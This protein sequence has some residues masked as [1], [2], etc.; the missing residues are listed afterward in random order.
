MS[1]AANARA[2]ILRL[3]EEWA[4]AAAEGDLERILSFWADDASVFPPGSPALVGKAAIRE[5]VAGSL[6]APGFSISWKTSDLVVA[7]SGELAY[8]IGANRVSFTAPDGKTVAI[9]GRAVTVWRK[10][11][12]GWKCVIDI[13]NGS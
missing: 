5:Y 2:E 13:W 3:D 6:R 4:R 12:G 1:P 10:D 8:G 11:A 7:A 9:D